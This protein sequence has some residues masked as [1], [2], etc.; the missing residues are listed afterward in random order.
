MAADWI[1][2]GLP[3]STDPMSG[4]GDLALF[5]GGGGDQSFVGRLL[6]L[7][8]TA[9]PNSGERLAALRR[10]FP[11]EVRVYE[12]WMTM[13][14]TPTAD[15][16]RAALDALPPLPVEHTI[17]LDTATLSA[18]HSGTL[19]RVDCSCAWTGAQL[20]LAEPTA[21]AEWRRHADPGGEQAR[22]AVAVI[23]Q[24]DELRD[25]LRANGDYD[26]Q[27]R[28][29]GP[30]ATIVAELVHRGRVLNEDLGNTLSKRLAW[31]LSTLR[32]EIDTNDP[33]PKTEPQ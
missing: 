22:A 4:T 5:L 14:P 20:H 18:P 21:H 31:A 11:R 26:V 2:S 6:D 30:Y 3:G 27:L 13:D 32:A 1:R 15:Q 23:A 25:L 33:T 19:I 29:H 16:L 10:G 8:A 28:L 17:R 24:I 12:L 9:W 7:I